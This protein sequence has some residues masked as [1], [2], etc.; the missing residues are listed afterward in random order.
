MLLTHVAF[1]RIPLLALIAL[2]LLLI[3]T[4][5]ALIRRA[6]FLKVHKVPKLTAGQLKRAW[7]TPTK[8]YPI[9]V[10]LGAIVILAVQYRRQK[11]E[12]EVT[13]QRE[14]GVVVR[15]IDGPWQVSLR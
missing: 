9:P 10:A 5:L 2:P 8:W 7:S 15:G 14:G 3:N 11:H 13:S 1:P 12:P 6:Y 4:P